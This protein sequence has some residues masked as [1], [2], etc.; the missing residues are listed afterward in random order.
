M[1]SVWWITEK[2]RMLLG[3]INARVGK[4]VDTDNAISMFEK[5][6]YILT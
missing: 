6:M 4:L 2:L 5:E 3:D 1:Y